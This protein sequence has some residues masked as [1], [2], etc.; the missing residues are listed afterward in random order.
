MKVSEL[1]ASVVLQPVPKGRM[2]RLGWHGGYLV[3]EYPPTKKAPSVKYIVG[4][5]VAEAEREKL[6]RVPYPDSLLQILKDKHRWKTH[7]VAA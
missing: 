7:K 4:P 1:L 3:V 2:S 6:L 5:D